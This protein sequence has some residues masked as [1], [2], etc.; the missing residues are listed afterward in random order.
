[1]N[2]IIH[3]SV[4][5][6]TSFVLLNV[7]IPQFHQIPRTAKCPAFLIRRRMGDE[8]RPLSGFLPKI[9]NS[10]EFL[11]CAK[12]K[13]ALNAEPRPLLG[14]RFGNEGCAVSSADRY[15][16]TCKCTGLLKINF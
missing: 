5:I 8:R 9:I 3:F 7:F 11:A 10:S 6:S 16:N 14:G 12:L 15:R 13:M 2:E 1:M 4:F